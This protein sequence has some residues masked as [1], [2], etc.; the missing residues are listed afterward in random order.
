FLS[1]GGAAA[2]PQG[3]GYAGQLSYPLKQY[4][5]Y[6]EGSY[7]LTDAL[8]LTLGLRGFKYNA[9]QD[10][11][12]YGF[13]TASG[14]LTPNNASASASATGAT[15]K[16]NLSYRPS[17]NL[18]LYAQI[19][20]GF[21]PGGANQLAPEALCGTTGPESYGPDSIWNYEIGEKA[22]MLGG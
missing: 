17:D 8:I 3:V 16:V 5:A 9:H 21:R 1:T 7:N 2:N 20:K 6:A 12:A 14:N 11:S 10:V 4:A 15:P 13:F 18:T 22:R 19:A